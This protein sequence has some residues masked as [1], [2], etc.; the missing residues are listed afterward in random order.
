MITQRFFIATLLLLGLVAADM[1]AQ[2]ALSENDR[3]RWLSEIREYKH[4]FLAKDLELTRE[5]QRDFFPLYDSME[6]EVER[7][8]TETRALE[9]KVS[10]SKEA[11]DL[12]IEN[13][14]RTI[15]EQKRAE[16]QIEMTYF[17]KFKE[18]LSPRQLLRLKNAERR[19][20]QQ[21]VKHHRRVNGKQK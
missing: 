1:N 17:D 13:A 16:G 6:D 11:S 19:F 21:L 18:I 20:T 14:S 2:S 15:F 7:I 5:Q 8:N 12:E 10:E 3:S 9:T 4:E